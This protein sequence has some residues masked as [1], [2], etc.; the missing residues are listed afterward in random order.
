M[1]TASIANSP[2]INPASSSAIAIEYGSSP[3]AQGADRTR[4][5]RGAQAANF[6]R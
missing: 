5:G 4:N 6:A 2:G 3:V 1:S